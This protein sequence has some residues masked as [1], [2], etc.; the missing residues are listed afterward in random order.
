MKLRIYVVLMGNPNCC[1]MIITGTFFFSSQSPRGTV[2]RVVTAFWTA[3]SG[4]WFK[5][6]EELFHTQEMVK[7]SITRW[8]IGTFAPTLKV[9]NIGKTSLKNPYKICN[10]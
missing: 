7:R 4:A 8:A 1:F 9:Q 6:V 5:L 2:T 3:N 10:M